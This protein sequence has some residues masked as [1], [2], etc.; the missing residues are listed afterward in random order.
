[1]KILHLL[2]SPVFSGP[3]ENVALLALEQRRLGHEV[4]VAVD[5]KRAGSTS[6]EPAAARL[7]A[8]ELLDEGGLELSVKST[9]VAVW[10]DLRLLHRREVD[11][12]HA[13]FT[14]DHFLA[15]LSRPRHA[16][17]V[18]SVHAPR[19][20]RR[21]LPAADGFTVPFE[22]ERQRLGK[23]RSIVLP[24]L[25]GPEFRVPGDRAALR[26][27]LG[28][29]GAPLV[30]M[31][32]TFQPSRRHDV[33]LE[34]F[35]LLVAAQPAARLVLVG[36]GALEPRLR[37]RAEALGISTAVTF[38][39][40]Q[41]GERFAE[42]LQ[43]LDQLWVLGLGN[44][45]SGRVAAQARACGARVVAAAIGG[46]P[47]LADALVKAEPRELLEGA[48]SLLHPP[49]TGPSGSPREGVHHLAPSGR[50]PTN[51]EIAARVLALYAEAG[52]A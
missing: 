27:R 31:A 20:I 34:A 14:H 13:H 36:D 5:R 12:L 7:A 33:A 15:R 38:T 2:S 49:T 24:A 28:L 42:H 18:R 41:Q 11:V 47:T 29:E 39:G 40:Y 48:L 3:A 1:M 19:S 8:L 45:F 44:D 10:T 6:E 52:G 46:L 4:T 30:G 25:V 16:V 22:S 51:E 9:P 23:R 35:A 50:P 43:A 21:T 37:A 32:S 17:I 26:A